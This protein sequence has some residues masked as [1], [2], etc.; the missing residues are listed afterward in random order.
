MSKILIVDDEKE[1]VELLRLVLEKEQHQ[2]FPAFSGETALQELKHQTPDLILLDVTMPGM[3]GYTLMSHL[4][5]EEAT[6]DIPVMILTGRE[7]MRDTFEVFRTV[8][9]FVSKPFD[10]KELRARVQAA[11]Q[12][13]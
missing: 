11:L 13:G 10:I 9:D 6:R 2:I 1:T 4:Q 12:K 5:S 7:N 8:V 3:D